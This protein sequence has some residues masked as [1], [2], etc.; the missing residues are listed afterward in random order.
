M[1]TNGR[2]FA[3]W[4]NDCGSSTEE[5][6]EAGRSPCYPQTPQ[7]NRRIV[8]I[9][10]STWNSWLGAS[11]NTMTVRVTA[12]SAVQTAPFEERSLALYCEELGFQYCQ[13]HSCGPGLCGPETFSR[14]TISY[15]GIECA[16]AGDCDDG[17]VCT[18]DSCVDN[19]CVHTNNTAS[20]S[21]GLFCT[22]GDT[23][24]GGV[25]E[26]TGGDPCTSG[27]VCNEQTDSCEPD[28]NDNGAADSADIAAFFSLDCNVNGTPDECDIADEV[29]DDC[30]LN[31]TPDECEPL[32]AIAIYDASLGLLP[33]AADPAWPKT[34]PGNIDGT[35]ANDLLAV[36][37]NSITS[38]AAYSISDVFDSA[39]QS[40]VYEFTGRAISGS[41]D[42]GQPIV[43]ISGLTDG[44]RDIALTVILGKVGILRSDTSDFVTGCS[45]SMTTD[46]AL[47]TYR[48]LKI[49][50]DR[51]HVFADDDYLFSCPYTDLPTASIERALLLATSTDG[52]SKFELASMRY[53]IGTISLDG[54]DCNDNDVADSCDIVA[55]TSA[56]AF[57]NGVPDECEPV[58]VTA[59]RSMRY[60]Q[61]HL[62]SVTTHNCG[63]ANGYF[64]L[65]VSLANDTIEMRGPASDQMLEVDFSRPLSQSSWDSLTQ[66]SPDLVQSDLSLAMQRHRCPLLS[67]CG[68]TIHR[69]DAGH[70]RQ[71]LLGRQHQLRG[72]SQRRTVLR[73]AQ[74]RP[75][76]RKRESSC[77]RS[78]CLDYPAGRRR[79][80][81]RHRGHRRQ[82]RDLRGLLHGQRC[83]SLRRIG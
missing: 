50:N 10:A 77:G 57:D 75:R 9:P 58:Q 82:D 63:D 65:D 17:N 23:C 11:G 53:A 66:S 5:C 56:D 14:V 70:V 2:F 12:S 16:D 46:D 64:C 68:G 69:P 4:F 62:N 81:R 61:N 79:K 51:I 54:A 28:C 76:R 43:W 40:A 21:D 74:C 20:C 22:T 72:D 47:H 7:P 55:G 13:G 6:L 39:S 37:D 41:R 83:A 42:F 80:R 73:A 25:C 34:S 44:S 15:T 67:H 38:R 35:I 3:E 60:H 19:D 52:L 59:I 27:E 32:A 31:G 33:P 30:D 26:G 45:A 71:L 29:S 78:Q 18:D 24:S 8:T 36:D 48:V 1:P 49:G